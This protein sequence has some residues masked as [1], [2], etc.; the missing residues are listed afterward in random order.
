[1]LK[2]PSKRRERRR[3]S[4]LRKTSVSSTVD[5]ISANS[6]KKSETSERGR[7]YHQEMWEAVGR[8]FLAEIFLRML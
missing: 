2:K 5:D 3:E 4:E 7:D 6:M 1:M 8:H